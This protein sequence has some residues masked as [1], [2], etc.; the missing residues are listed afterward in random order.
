MAKTTGPGGK[1]RTTPR[2]GMAAKQA[3]GRPTTVRRR[4]YEYDHEYGIK[5]SGKTAPEK[6]VPGQK[7]ARKKPA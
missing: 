5:L 1:Q 3:E 4:A 2:S 6:K 7:G